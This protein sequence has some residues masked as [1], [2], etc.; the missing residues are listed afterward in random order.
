MRKNNLSNYRPK[1]L[2]SLYTDI[3]NEL[4]EREIIKA[5]NNPVS[6]VAEWLVAK[7]FK[8][9]LQP[10]SNEGFDA[11]D[12]KTNTRYE[13]KARRITRYNKS[14]QLGVIRDLKKKRFDFL[15]GIIFDEY[16]SVLEAYKIPHSLIAEYAH[17][18]NHQNGHILRLEEEGICKDKRVKKIEKKLQKCMQL[19]K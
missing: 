5:F 17:Y 7:A 16:F 10:N 6:G 1:K 2:L 19:L 15:I 8:L 18:N 9:K 4:K 13:I 12:E 3:L 11:I 14:R